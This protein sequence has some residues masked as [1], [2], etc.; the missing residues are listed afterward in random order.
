MFPATTWVTSEFQQPCLGACHR[1][2]RWLSASHLHLENPNPPWAA[3]RQMLPNSATQG[4][5]EFLLQH[6]LSMAICLPFENGR[7]FPHLPPPPRWN[8]AAK[9]AKTTV[10]LIWQAPVRCEQKKDSL[11]R[12]LTTFSYTLASSQGTRPIPHLDSRRTNTSGTAVRRTTSGRRLKHPPIS[13][14]R[15]VFVLTLLLK[16][17]E[18]TLLLANQSF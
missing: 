1:T 6:L 12:P 8:E 13:R 18:R 17:E 14:C 11:P 9:S 3:Q 4:N 2:S 7:V 16:L 5:V 10:P 15:R